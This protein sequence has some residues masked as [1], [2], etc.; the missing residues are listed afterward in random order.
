VCEVF[1]WFSI[2]KISNFAKRIMPK[3]F[4]AL[5]LGRKILK[6]PFEFEYLIKLVQLIWAMVLL[7]IGQQYDSFAKRII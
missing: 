6:S 2:I 7:D 3:I 4:I 1:W 5:N